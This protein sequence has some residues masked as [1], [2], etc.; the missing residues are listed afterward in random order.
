MP[1]G[2]HVVAG[3]QP[4]VWAP[5]AAAGALNQVFLFPL[6]GFGRSPDPGL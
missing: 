2:V 6:T 3:A 4:Q 5:R 1:E